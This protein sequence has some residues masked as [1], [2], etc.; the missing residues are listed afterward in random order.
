MRTLRLTNPIEPRLDALTRLLAADDVWSHDGDQSKLERGAFAISCDVKNERVTAIELRLPADLGDAPVADR[1][2]I[3]RALVL[4][5]FGF[6]IAFAEQHLPDL[7]DEIAVRAWLS[8]PP[9]PTAAEAH[10]EVLNQLASS[11][12]V[13]YELLGRALDDPRADELIAKLAKGAPAAE[14]VPVG[15]RD[16]ALLSRV[17]ARFNAYELVGPIGGYANRTK[18]RFLASGA[19]PRTAAAARLCLFFEQ[20]RRVHMATDLG[21]ADWRYIDALLEVVRRG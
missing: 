3:A 1:L 4:L 6:S 11:R 7:M 8:L 16:R 15:S 21:D 14:P 18:S 9:P 13:D 2:A 19:V 20:R 5:A 12:A 17:S 10:D